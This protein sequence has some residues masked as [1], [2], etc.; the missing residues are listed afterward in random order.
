M[1]M[2]IMKMSPF[3]SKA[4]SSDFHAQNSTL[5]FTYILRKDSFVVT[6]I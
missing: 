1:M 5:L 6:C 4:A 3:D 2:M